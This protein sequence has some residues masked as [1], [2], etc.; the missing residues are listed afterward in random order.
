MIQFQILLLPPSPNLG[1]S[2]LLSL[3]GLVLGLTVNP[4]IALEEIAMFFS[5]FIFADSHIVLKYAELW[6]R[7]VIINF[8]FKR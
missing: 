7:C 2:A 8:L 6:H 5:I 3:N 1:M 4:Q